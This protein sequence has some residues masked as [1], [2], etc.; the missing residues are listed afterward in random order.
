MPNN[1][2]A[3]SRKMSTIIMNLLKDRLDEKTVSLLIIPDDRDIPE[4]TNLQ[5]I[6]ILDIAISKNLNLN[7]AD[8]GQVISDAS[9][10]LQE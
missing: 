7:A 2:A 9:K 5:Q 4:I 10:R 6:P 1:A 3:E 8:I